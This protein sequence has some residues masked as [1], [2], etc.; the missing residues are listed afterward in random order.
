MFNPVSGKKVNTAF[1]M[2]N[3]TDEEAFDNLIFYL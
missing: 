1:V 3:I 2:E